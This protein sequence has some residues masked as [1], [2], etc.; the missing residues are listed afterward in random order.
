VYPT[1]TRTGG[2]IMFGIEDSANAL[3]AVAKPSDTKSGY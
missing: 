2:V 1:N 3:V